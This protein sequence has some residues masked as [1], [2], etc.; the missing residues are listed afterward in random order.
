MPAS[1]WK[2]HIA[3]GLIIIPVRLL[4]AARSERVPLRELY[5][6]ESPAP[7]GEDDE[8]VAPSTP[9]A[10]K[11]PVRTDRKH[12]AEPEP[13]PEPVFEPVRHIS[14][15]QSSDERA[16]ASSITKGYEYERGR[17]VTLASEELRS[18]APPTSSAMEITAFLRLSEIEGN[19]TAGRRRRSAG[20]T[21]PPS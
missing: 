16:P 15:G 18:I 21:M 5:Q 1:V 17:F 19:G 3:F 13:A 11:G 4:R 20:S 10:A 9:A 14:V 12:E 7:P 2:G 6:T 8:D